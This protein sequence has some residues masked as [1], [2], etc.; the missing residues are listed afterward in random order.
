MCLISESVFFDPDEARDLTD[1]KID[2]LRSIYEELPS[3]RS[4]P[5]HSII[6]RLE[7]SSEDTAQIFGLLKERDVIFKAYSFRQIIREDGLERLRRALLNAPDGRLLIPVFGL[8]AEYGQLSGGFVNVPEPK[9]SE[10][11]EEML[12]SLII[13]L[14][15]MAWE[16]DR[17][18]LLVDSLKEIGKQ[19]AMN[20][21]YERII[22][23][24]E[25]S[26]P[27]GHHFEKFLMEFG[28]MVPADNFK[29]GKR[30]M[31]LLQN[32]LRRRTSKFADPVARLDFNLPKGIIEL[33]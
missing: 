22:N 5:L 10:E 7:G 8:L 19:G 18:E 4:V 12:A 9:A 1:L 28:K 16:V 2:D 33:L 25:H 23:T 31:R 32:A 20:G 26:Q 3:G 21:V 11:L 6:N 14:A 29:L 13:A 24:L 17:T 27:S 15:N 30:Y